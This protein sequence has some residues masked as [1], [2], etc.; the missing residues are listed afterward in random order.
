VAQK[1]GRHS[2]A[3][4]LK[5]RL[6]QIACGYEDQNDAGS[7]RTNPLLKL[8]CGALPGSGKDLAS[9]PTISR[10]ENAVSPRA[11]Y[12]IAEAL[13]MSLSALFAEANSASTSSL[14]HEGLVRSIT[15]LYASTGPKPF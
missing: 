1:R 4:L 2:L 12:W 15:C 14:R 10:M 9:Q 11:C 5:Q 6:Y 8:V 7:L 13:G 3:S